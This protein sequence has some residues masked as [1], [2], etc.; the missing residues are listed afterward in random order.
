MGRGELDVGTDGG[1]GV[2]GGWEVDSGYGLLSRCD[3]SFEQFMLELNFLD[4]AGDC[5]SGGGLGEA[6]A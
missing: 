6:P 2:D 5:K 1:V 3:T 4:Q